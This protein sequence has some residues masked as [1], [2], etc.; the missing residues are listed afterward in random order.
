MATK[1]IGLERAEDI[2]KRLRQLRKRR[3]MTYS[4]IERVTSSV[5]LNSHSHIGGLDRAY[6]SRVENGHAKAGLVVLERWAK[7][8]KMELWQIFCDVDEVDAKVDSL[9]SLNSMENA[10]H[11]P[12]HTESQTVA[13]T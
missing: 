13:E 12:A 7:A 9:E 6:L 10:G 8:L 1:I 4:D 5:W 11:N 3:K 2:G